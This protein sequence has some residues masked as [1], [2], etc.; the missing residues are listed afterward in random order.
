VIQCLTHGEA[1]EVR[2]NAEA[3]A[4]AS[5]NADG[6]GEDVQHREHGRGEDGHRE[7]LIHRQLLP[8][9]EYK[10]QG[11]REAL[12]YVLDDARKKVID[13]HLVYIRPIDFFSTS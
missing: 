3:R 13:V 8:G 11:Y 12:H 7:D 4:L 1:Y 9:N 6:G 2:A 10:R 5:R